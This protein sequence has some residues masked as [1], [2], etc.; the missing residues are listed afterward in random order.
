MKWLILFLCA[1]F[2]KA[3]HIKRSPLDGNPF[4]TK[5]NATP[6][7][8]SEGLVAFN[9]DLF[10]ALAFSQKGNV[11]F[12]PFSLHTALSMALIGAPNNTMT[13]QQLAL[14]LNMRLEHAEDYLYNYLRALQFYDSVKANT[15]IKLANKAFADQKLSIKAN[16]LTVLE[17][18]Y[19]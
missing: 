10:S 11:A 18:F 8:L 5:I 4:V 6:F 13:Y 9:G 2:I 19:R 3:A 15:K 17:L 7:R 1:A 12:S 16:Y 14:A